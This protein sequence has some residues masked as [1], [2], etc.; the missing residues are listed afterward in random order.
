MTVSIVVEADPEVLGDK[1]VQPAVEGRFCDSAISVREA[2]LEL[3]GRH[4]SSHP[5]VGLKYFEKVVERIKDTGVS[6]RK[7]SIK[8]IRDMCISNRDFSEFTSACIAIISRIGDDESSI[9][10][11]VCMTFYEFWFE[12]QTGSHTQFF[13]D[14]SSVPLEMAKITDRTQF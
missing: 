2:A 12:E 3:V 10:D 13:G 5:D 8:I 11:L 14:D 7:R 9:Q 4:I 6:V 1:R